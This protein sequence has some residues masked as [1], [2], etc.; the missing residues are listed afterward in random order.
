MF[1]LYKAKNLEK[2]STWEAV[3]ILG[4]LFIIVVL[5]VLPAAGF[6]GPPVKP[7]PGSPGVIAQNTQSTNLESNSAYSEVVSL[8]VGNAAYSVDPSEEYITIVNQGSSP[9]NLS[10]W[11][12]V[13]S[14]GSQEYNTKTRS[15][16]YVPEEITIPK[17]IGYVLPGA[18]FN[19][20]QNVILEPGE[21][22]VITSGYQLKDSPY[23][24]TS[25]K[26]NICTNY[27]EALPQYDFVPT[28]TNR[29]SDLNKEPGID[30]LTAE[31]KNFVHLAV[32]T[33]STPVFGQMDKKVPYKCE[34]CVN[35]LKAPTVAC[36]NYIK[37][38]FSYPG[39][40]ANHKNDEDFYGDTWRI[41]LGRPSEFWGVNTEYISLY[42]QFNKLISFRSY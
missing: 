26:E 14:K 15:L 11:K 36:Y 9:I 1:R 25:F 28:I 3:L 2:G 23:K 4:A 17:A 12:L 33:C 16:E 27:L 41:F 31:C 35:G 8:N 34:G 32:N 18:G 6:Y 19:L 39:C 22:A 42:D 5:F 40:I 29:C 10:G 13:N 38:H 37:D 30:T 7:Y 20:P 24:I 21:T